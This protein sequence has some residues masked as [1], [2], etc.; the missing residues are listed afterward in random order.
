[1]I[2]KYDNNPSI[3]AIKYSLSDGNFFTFSNV[4]VNEIYN[5]LIKMDCKK[6]LLVFMTVPVNYW[7]WDQHLLV[8]QYVT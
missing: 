4:T 8:V 5:M 3:I 6:N 1:M 2:A 7:E